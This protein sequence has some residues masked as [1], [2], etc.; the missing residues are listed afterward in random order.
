MGK[1]NES[2]ESAAFKL[3]NIIASMPGWVYWKNKQGQFLGC[4]EA[5]AESLGVAKEEIIGRDDYFLA[6]KL[7]P[8]RVC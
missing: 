6:K 8:E 7:D 2:K 4:N 1:L 3:D 5:L